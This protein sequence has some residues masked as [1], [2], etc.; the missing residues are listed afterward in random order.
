MHRL[1][2]LV[3]PISEHSRAS[4]SAFLKKLFV[5]SSLRN[6]D[7]LVESWETLRGEVWLDCKFWF[8]EWF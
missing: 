3:L 1:W 4:C 7:R 8:F 2:L 5:R 6:S